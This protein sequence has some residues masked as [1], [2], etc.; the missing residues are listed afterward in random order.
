[1]PKLMRRAVVAFKQ[2]VTYG[3]DP[4]PT[5]AANAILVRDLDLTPMEQELAS[6]ELIRPYL[7]NSEDIPV[8]R[9]M[10]A[11]F[12][13]ELAGSGTAGTAPAWG[14]LIMAC[15]FAEADGVSDVVYTPK[16]TGFTS[17]TLYVNIDGVLHEA[18]GCAGNVAFA[19]D[20]R[21]IPMLRFTFSGL[22]VPVVDA[23]AF[24]PT[25]TAFKKPV[26]INKQYTTLSLH[27]L[28]A[29]VEALQLD[30]NNE[31]PY[32]NLIGFEGVSVNDRKPGGSITMEMVG[33][34]THNWFSTIDTAGTGALQLVHG[35]TAG[36]IIQIDAPG[37]Q[38]VSPRFT[39]SQGIQ[40][41][42]ANLKLVPGGSGDD[43]ITITVK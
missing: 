19:L 21:S 25:Y 31:V 41:L 4:T 24:S 2:E 14:P 29:V 37:V 11:A 42:Q 27:G 39:N 13:V 40:M 32:R 36:N 12:N 38:L 28:A 20:A 9:Y 6:R 5:G 17:G 1:M 26:P 30:M 16:S 8:A 22:F 34:A 35:L 23:A 7:G 10:K 33:V 18:N 15:G 3:V 43:E